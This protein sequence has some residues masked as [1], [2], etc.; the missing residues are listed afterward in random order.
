MVNFLLALQFL[1]RIPLSLNIHVSDQQWGRTVLFYPLVGAVIGGAL[2]LITLLS[3]H[4]TNNIQAAL[5]L[6][7]WV[8]MTG[9]LHL[10]GLADCAD[11]WAGGLN[12]RAK[13]LKIM[14][15]PHIGALAVVILILVLGLKWIALSELFAQKNYHFTLI[16]IPVLGRNAILILMATSPYTSPNGL[17]ENLNKYFPKKEAL[18]I[19]FIGVVLGLYSVGFWAVL[20]AILLTF[21][22]RYLA[23]QRLKGVTGDVYGASVELVETLLLLAVIA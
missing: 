23:Q 4:F 10:D 2:T 9:G 12:D 7:G 20:L 18:I 5:V 11:G 6:S 16:M 15:D 13:T 14:K 21:S 8:L 22:I 3:P 17:A 1:T 19:L